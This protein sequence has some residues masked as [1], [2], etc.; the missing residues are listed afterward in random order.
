MKV[1]FLTKEGVRQC[2]DC[3]EINIL[4][5]FGCSFVIKQDF[6]EGLKIDSGNRF[7]SIFGERNADNSVTLKHV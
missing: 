5:E 4:D 2:V 7:K 1:S 6:D 3:E